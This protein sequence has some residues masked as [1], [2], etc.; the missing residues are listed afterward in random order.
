MIASL[1]VV[2]ASA[3]ALEEWLRPDS[4]GGIPWGSEQKP[5]E[6]E[7][8]SRSDYLP[9]SGYIGTD[10]ADRPADYELRAPNSERRFVRY[11]NDRLADAWLVRDG[12]INLL[13]LER[14]GDPDWAGVVLG[15]AEPG[16]RSFGY[17]RSWSVDS[18]TALHWADR[19]SETE[20]LVMR[21]GPTAS[22][23]VQR[24]SPID[25]GLRTSTRKAQIKGDLKR[26]VQAYAGEISGCL[27]QAPKPVEAKVSLRYDGAGRPARIKVETDQPSFNI[28]DCMAGAVAKTRAPGMTSG[29]FVA[30]RMR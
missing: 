21:A 9:D 26:T 14:I 10:P 7:R 11:I 25:E 4:A 20:I 22:Y 2:L 27:D 15:P 12:A 29:Q 23:A 8:K 28:T 13:D 1:L 16:W 30:F 17:A 19:L 18:R 5:S 6:M 3:W 24:A